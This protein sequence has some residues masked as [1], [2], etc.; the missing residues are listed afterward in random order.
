VRFEL[1]ATLPKGKYSALGVIDGGED[2]SLEAIESTIEV[3]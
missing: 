2:L 1:P 3:R